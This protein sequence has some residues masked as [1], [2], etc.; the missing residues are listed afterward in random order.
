VKQLVFVA[1]VVAAAALAPSAAAKVQYCAPTGDFCTSVAK[2][3]GVRTFR[4]TSFAF[5]GAVKICV[6]DPKGG[7]ACHSF[8]L[9]KMGPAYGT[10]I[11]WRG[12]YPDRGPGT[13]RVTFTLG[14]ARLGPV[15]AFV[16]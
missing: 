2:V 12:H 8:R 4:L 16:R 5:N 13:Y 14:S 9:S 7:R 11:R 15:L 3:K 6:R 10:S 1:V